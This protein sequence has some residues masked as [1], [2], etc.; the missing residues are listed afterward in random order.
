MASMAEKQTSGG[1]PVQAVGTTFEI[2]RALNRLE[3]AQLTELAD[4]LGISKTVVYNHLIT[5]S[6]EGFVVKDGDVYRLS[7]EFLNIGVRLRKEN[8][9][10]NAGKSQVNTLAEETS[11]F[12]HLM[13]F[14]QGMGYYV[15]RAKGSNAVATISR[16]GKRDYLHRTAAGK[17][18]LSELDDEEVRRIANERGLPSQTSNTITDVEELLSKLEEIRER[19]VAFSQEECVQG[20]CAVGAPVN[21]SEGEVLGAVS[22]SGPTARLK[23][24]RLENE[25]ADQVQKKANY[26]EMSINTSESGR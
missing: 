15:H 3:P 6:N 10:Y 24:E 1:R 4:H 14:E 22:I 21:S 25:L 12:A 11:E 2:V 9:L 17:A 26:I 13:F 7:L 19:G 5:L 18:I 16:V 8:V 23:D 20:A